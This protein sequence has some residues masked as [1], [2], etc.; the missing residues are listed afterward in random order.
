MVSLLG[1]CESSRKA[2]KGLKKSAFYKGNKPNREKDRRNADSAWL[3]SGEGIQ[4][5]G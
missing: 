5:L 3:F 4:N 1:P 2:H